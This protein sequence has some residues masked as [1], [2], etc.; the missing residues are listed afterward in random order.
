MP[1]YRTDIQVLRGFAI[2]SVVF[3]HANVS[4]FGAGYLGV[5]IFFVISGF[6]ITG[7]I[8]N[9]IERETF[10]FGEFYFRRAKRLLPAA[11]AT[12]FVTALVAPFFLD[13]QELTDYFKQLAGAITLTGNFVLWRQ[14]GYFEGAAELKP[15]L[16]VWSLGIEEQYYLI[17]PALLVLFARRYWLL[18]AVAVAALSLLTCLVIG[19]IRPNATFYLLPARAWELALGSVGAMATPGIGI[20]KKITILFWP[21]T[22]ALILL[23]TIPFGGSQPGLAALGVCTA[24]LVI[25][26]RRHPI[27][28]MPR[29][30]RVMTGL[31]NISYSLYLVHWPLISFFNNCWIGE[32]NNF[33]NAALVAI[34]IILAWLLYSYIEKP[35]HN[36]ETTNRARTT[37]AFGVFSGVLLLM[38]LAISHSFAHDIDYSFIRRPNFGFDGACESR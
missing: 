32:S 6:L 31:G 33:T 34:S 30:W 7:L 8:K 27:F 35:I 4:I 2:L 18:G 25:I 29:C 14:T 24:T 10:S 37:L 28:E 1:N 3:Y 5:D 17:M 21:S 15:L 19:P 38:P 9:R 26:L 22:A 20:Q 12:F 16:H 11:Y 23:P 13:A 36:L